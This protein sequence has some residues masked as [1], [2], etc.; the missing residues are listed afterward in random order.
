ML[1]SSILAGMLL[2]MSIS[3]TPITDITGNIVE[4]RIRP[5]KE[6]YAFRQGTWIPI[7]ATCDL[8]CSC[9]GTEP[10]CEKSN[11]DPRGLAH[12]CEFN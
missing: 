12:T 2:A 11:K 7:L 6:G 9:D 8:S 4:Y 3:V 10:D 5:V 1:K